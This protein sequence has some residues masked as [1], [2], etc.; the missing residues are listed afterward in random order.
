MREFEALY[1]GVAWWSPAASGPRGS[2]V[3]DKGL[4]IEV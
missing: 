3:R 4:V 2:V 1:S